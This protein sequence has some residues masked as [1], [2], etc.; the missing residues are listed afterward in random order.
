MKKENIL[1]IKDK[2]KKA[3]CRDIKYNE[4]KKQ[5]LLEDL[6]MIDKVLED[7]RERLEKNKY[8]NSR[9]ME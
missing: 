6:I 3:L 8:K 5:T 7:D 9:Q 4:R 1:N 2:G